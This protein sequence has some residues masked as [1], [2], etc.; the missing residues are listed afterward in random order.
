MY[1]TTTPTL[2]GGAIVPPVVGGV[3]DAVAGPTTDNTVAVG[4]VS[5]TIAGP[6]LTDSIVGAGGGDEILEVLGVKISRGDNPLVDAVHGVATGSLPMTG[7][8]GLFLILSAIT[9]I[10]MGMAVVRIGRNLT[11]ASA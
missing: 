9:L 2:V 8:N 1:H 7:V 11:A 10:L 4:G 5:E 3:V 6:G